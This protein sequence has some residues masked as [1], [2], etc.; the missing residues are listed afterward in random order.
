PLPE[1]IAMAEDAFLGPRLFLI[2]PSATDRTIDLVLFDRSQKGERLKFVTARV[3]ARLFLHVPRID[4]FLH[5]AH[6]QLHTMFGH[7]PIAEFDRFLEVVAGID[8]HQRERYA[9]RKEGLSCEVETYD[10]ILAT[11]EEQGR[12]FELGRH[13]APDVDA[14]ALQFLQVRK[15]VR[16]HFQRLISGST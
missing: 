12:T 5:A 4:A 8:V 13:L 2:A 16:M 1:I 7:E 3:E 9:A 11:A 14:F 10:R 6:D 15:S